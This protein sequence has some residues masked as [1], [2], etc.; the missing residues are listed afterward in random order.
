MEGATAA[1]CE[2]GGRVAPSALFLL[3]KEGTPAP[4]CWTCAV[5]HPRL[6]RNSVRTMLVVGPILALTNHGTHVRIRPPHLDG[7][8]GNSA[9]GRGAVRGLALGNAVRKPPLPCA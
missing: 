8:G 4:H 3:P 7:G 1:S 2:V 9:H 6:Q 5:K